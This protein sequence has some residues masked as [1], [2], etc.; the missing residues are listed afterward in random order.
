MGSTDSRA[1]EVVVL[2]SSFRSPGAR[3]SIVENSPQ[4]VV[5][6]YYVVVASPQWSQATSLAEQAMVVARV[7]E[8]NPTLEQRYQA[9]VDAGLLGFGAGE[10][11]EVDAAIRDVQRALSPQAEMTET[12]DDGLLGGG[13]TEEWAPWPPGG[14]DHLPM[15]EP[16]A[17]MAEPPAAPMPPPAM[18]EPPAAPPPAPDPIDAGPP[19]ADAES[20]D[21]EAVD[22]QPDEGEEVHT[23]L[24]VQLY[25]YE[26]PLAV[27][28]PY[29]LAVFFGEKSAAAQAAAPTTPSC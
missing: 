17:D 22:G 26:G 18:A 11:D 5:D 12:T 14:G 13:P 2:A 16:P 23:W 6:L 25:D 28:I 21:G 3:R 10:D 20:A 29:T 9:D 8:E 7:L 15:A 19:P 1:F 4:S 24:N 27:A